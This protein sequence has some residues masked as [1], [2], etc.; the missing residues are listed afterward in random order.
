M[1]NNRCMQHAAQSITEIGRLVSSYV[2]VKVASL[3]T[4][5]FFPKPRRRARESASHL[6]RVAGQG[7]GLRRFNA[8]VVVAAEP[9]PFSLGF[10]LMELR[11]EPHVYLYLLFF[12]SQLRQ[13]IESGD[14]GMP[15]CGPAPLLI[16]AEWCAASPRPGS[17]GGALVLLW[18]QP[19][20]G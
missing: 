19:I 1:T 20:F 10:L 11:G 18:S 6:G 13:P 3:Q 12:F 5:T 4:C 8:V 14:A 2:L 16:R 9:P 15:G 17:R 7:K